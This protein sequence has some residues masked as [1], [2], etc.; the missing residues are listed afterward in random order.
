MA[1]LIARS[2]APDMLPLEARGTHLSELWPDA[3]HWIAPLKGAAAE[4]DN[5]LKTAGLGLPGPGRS[6]GDEA[7]RIVWSGREQATLLGQ[8][9]AGL[10][11]LAAITDVTD[12]WAVMALSGPLAHATLA[13]LTPLDLRPT[14]FA[15]GA[16]ARTDLRHMMAQITR[17]G[18]EVFEIMVMRS[19]TGTAVHDLTT[20]LTSVAAQAL[21]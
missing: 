19:F 17:T 14:K 15:V 3:I 8:L 2:P 18:P 16:T 21:D 6:L 12:G 13:R 7:R 10:D 20:A 9:P 4:L 5:R 11:D 1:N